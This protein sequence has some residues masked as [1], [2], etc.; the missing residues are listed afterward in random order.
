[1]RGNIV[2]NSNINIFEIYITPFMSV[3]CFEEFLNI[4]LLSDYLHE[5]NILFIEDIRVAFLN[6]VPNE[7]LR[8]FMENLMEIVRLHHCNNINW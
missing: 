5:D 6:T 7:S 4:F 2:G 8:K 3:E 1:M